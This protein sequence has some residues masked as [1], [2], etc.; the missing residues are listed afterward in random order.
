MAGD[1]EQAP[2]GLGFPGNTDVEGALARADAARAA[3]AYPVVR[4]GPVLAVAEQGSQGRWRVLRTGEFTSQGARD[5]PGSPLRREAAQPGTDVGREAERGRVA[6]L[7]AARLL[8]RERRDGLTV[9]G[10]G[11]GLPAWRSLSGS[12]LMGPS[13]PRPADADA[14]PPGK[15][16]RGP[17]PRSSA[18]SRSCACAPNGPEPPR[19]SGQDP[20]PSAEA[21]ASGLHPPS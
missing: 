5:T 7:A 9:E 21:R 20:D 12:G 13:P 8:D 19:G 11:S 15:G 6:L 4:T 1:K 18:W 14:W 17:D 10:G 3:R 16:H 2:G